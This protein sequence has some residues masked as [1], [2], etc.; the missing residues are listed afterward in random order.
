MKDWSKEMETVLLNKTANYS[1]QEKEN[2]QIEYLKNLITKIKTEELIIEKDLQTKI[3][4]VIMDLPLKT[5]NEKVV[6]KS[7]HINEITNLQTAKAQKFNLVKKKHYLRKYRTIGIAI[8]LMIGIPIAT[9]FGKIALGPIIGTTIG[10]FLGI[11]IGNR[12]DNKAEFE[13]RVL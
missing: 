12:R 2:L 10:L 5:N 1:E 13:N 3:E 11:I 9:A 7:K 8:G 6:Y 4:G